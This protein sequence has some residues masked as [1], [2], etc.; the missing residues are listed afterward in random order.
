MNPATSSSSCSV[1]GGRV[2]GGG[3]LRGANTA[4]PLAVT[5]AVL[6]VVKTPTLEPGKGVQIR[7][8]C[9]DAEA[10]EAWDNA[11]IQVRQ[12]LSPTMSTTI[13]ERE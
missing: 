7:F 2:G 1:R 13:A 11:L 3:G 5:S 10:A 9:F 8:L 4:A 6:E 12:N